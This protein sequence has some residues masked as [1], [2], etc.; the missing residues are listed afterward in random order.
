[1]HWLMIGYIDIIINML[2]PTKQIFYFAK[3]GQYNIY[4]PHH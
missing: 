3:S 4:T 2:S 1:M